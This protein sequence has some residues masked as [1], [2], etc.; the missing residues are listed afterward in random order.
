MKEG[1]E[2]SALTRTLQFLLWMKSSFA[3]LS[4]LVVQCFVGRICQSLGTAVLLVPPFL[5][6]QRSVPRGMSVRS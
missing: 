1:R 5:Y 3:L 4:W 6:E 2:R